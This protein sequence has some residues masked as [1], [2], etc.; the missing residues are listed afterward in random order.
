MVAFASGN[1]RAAKRVIKLVEENV[2]SLCLDRRNGGH[3]SADD[4][5]P[6]RVVQPRRE[7]LGD[8]AI[9]VEDNLLAHGTYLT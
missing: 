6:I 7:I 5:W 8:S 9:E 4:D 2:E 3:G 1:A